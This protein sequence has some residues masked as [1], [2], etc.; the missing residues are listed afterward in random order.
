VAPRKL[1]AVWWP[2]AAP[3]RKAAAKH[4]NPVAAWRKIAMVQSECEQVNQA[5]IMKN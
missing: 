4:R 1:L 3:E 5:G 2:L